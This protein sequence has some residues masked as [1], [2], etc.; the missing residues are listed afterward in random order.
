MKRGC[1]KIKKVCICGINSQYIHS[2]PA[3]YSLAA[4]YYEN[5]R[6]S[7]TDKAFS[8]TIK[9]Y[10]VNDII[11]NILLDIA[12]ERPEVL[13]FSVY[14]WN[15]ETVKKLL[16]DVSKVLPETQVV[17]G[18]PEVSFGTEHCGIDDNLFDFVIEGEGELAFTEF[19]DTLSGEGK[20]PRKIRAER[21]LEMAE[22]PFI[23]EVFDLARFENRIIYYETSRGCPFGCSYC[24]SGG[25]KSPVRFLPVETVFRHIDFFAENNVPLVKFVDRT[26]NC[27]PERA[28]AIV[29]K[30]ASLPETCRTCFHFEVGA[31]LFDNDF[32]GLLATLPKGRVQIEAGIQSTNNEVLSRCVRKTDNNRVFDNLQKICSYGNINVHTDL[33]AGLPGE[34]LDSFKNSFNDV[35][36]LRSHQFQLGFLK[37]LQGAPLCDTEKAD[38]LVFSENSPYEILES[39]CLSFGEITE[40]KEVEAALERYYNSGYYV[41]TL[42]RVDGC[43]GTSYEFYRRLAEYLK[44]QGLLWGGVSKR[45]AFDGL[46]EFCCGGVNDEALAETMLLDY[47]SSDKSE[48][49]PDSLRFVWRHSRAY[50][51]SESEVYK[52][53]NIDD[54]A[55]FGIR[56]VGGNAYVFDYRG[57]DPVTGRYSL[58]GVVEN[59]K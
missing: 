57:K 8:V 29:G 3:V 47:F 33:I 43:F 20:L 38:G 10:T 1:V 59:V 37:R 14:I 11:G 12:A 34:N 45:R 41:E 15:V 24:L 52:A 17:I 4:Y 26:F 9:E 21:L 32:L 50:R 58:G 19:L 39:A 46:Y 23:Y 16:S 36:A 55:G 31:D 18:G 28:K 48:L 40:L 7:G 6:F 25:D 2:N 51:N 49:P 44:G 13:A 56:Y 5:S 22:I 42:K 30:I 54:F 53:L 35:Y 27:N